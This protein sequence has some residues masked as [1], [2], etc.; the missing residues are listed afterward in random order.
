MQKVILAGNPNTGKTTLFNTMTKSNEKAGNWHGVTVAE[1]EKKYTFQNTDF[2]LCDLPG[3]YSLDG[4]SEE[5]QIS[6]NYLASNE[7]AIVVCILDANNLKRNL[8]LALELKEKTKNLI[9]AVNMAKEVKSFDENK[10]SKCLDVK[11]IGIDAR[12]KKSITRL[13]EEIFNMSKSLNNANSE[14][15]EFHMQAKSL[16]KTQ[17]KENC[18][19]VVKFEENTFNMRDFEAKSQKRFEQIDTI[20]SEANY[21]PKGFYGS[22]KA[23]KII[24]NGFGAFV[25]FAFIMG[26]V[27]YITFGSIGAFLSSLIG[28]A[29]ESFAA[30][31]MG[32]L[33]KFISSEPLL[34]FIEEGVLGGALTVLTFMPQ[35]VL[36]FT[37]LNFLEDMGYL[38]RVAFMFDGIFKK[39]GLTGKATFS[40]IMGF[41]CTT[42]AVMTTRNLDSPCLKKRTA[43]LLPYMSCSAKLPIYAVICSAFFAR[44]KALIVFAL[45][46]FAILLM[47]LVSLILK[48]IDKTKENDTFM[49]E[50]PKYRMPYLSKVIKGALSSAKEFFIR[51]G[52]VLLLSSMIIFLLYNFSFNLTYVGS[53]TS[54]SILASFA[55]SMSFIFIPLGFGT[56][57]AVIAILSGIIAKEMVVSSLAI[58]NGVSTTMLAVSLA[59][60]SSAV[61]FTTLSAI[62]FLIFVLL[63]MPC[64]S[65]VLSMKKEIGTKNTIFSVVLQFGVAYLASMLV[66]G[67][68]SLFA[69]GYWWIGCL[70]IISLAIILLFVVKYLLKKTK[71]TIQVEFSNKC[72][73]CKEKHCGNNKL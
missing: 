48:A 2:M 40:L 9:L 29:F 3:L 15:Q 60:P 56:A 55:G 39:I 32:W 20:L 6:A 47:L 19:Q 44:H 52:G 36:L 4:Y 41:G 16:N 49:L 26:L 37:C 23:D 22:S 14:R 66:Y 28:K 67:V 13:K 46:M 5:E 38:S 54:K 71:N 42:T 31:F 62:S 53:E 35:I 11:V 10:L 73:T 72:I 27:F 30:W 51:V 17:E 63:Y 34:K 64:V 45:Y 59:N 70:C 33:G 8:Y 25:V 43:L 61:H 12:K 18:K 1:K 21:N 7:N 50:M 69:I 24:L 65:A 58:V 68:G 57:G